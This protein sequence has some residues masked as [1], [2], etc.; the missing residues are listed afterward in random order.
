MN[1]S[2]LLIWF[3]WGALLIVAEFF[4]PGILLVF[5]G[6]SAWVI[7]L[8]LALHMPHSIAWEVGI[9][10]VLSI[11]LLFTLRGWLQRQFK[12]FTTHKDDLTRMPS[13]AIGERVQ[14]AEDINSA[15][16]TGRVRWKGALWKAQADEPIPA[17]TTV[18]IVAQDNLVLKVK[19]SA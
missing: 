10:V 1:I 8:L 17:G 4:V 11:V 18:V 7:A 15:T 3:I 12:G 14:V 5:F 6:A 19:R 13:E 2:P 16:M 9:W